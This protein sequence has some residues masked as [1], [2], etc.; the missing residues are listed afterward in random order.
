MEEQKECKTCH[1]VKPVTKFKYVRTN[2]K[3]KRYYGTECNSCRGIASKEITQK[4]EV[5]PFGDKQNNKC[6]CCFD[7]EQIK[8][9]LRLI[10]T[11]ELDIDKKD[12]IPK[13]FNINQDLYYK[14]QQYSKA[15][16]IND[17]D[18]INLILREFFK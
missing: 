8:L 18:S 1:E 10:D 4:E 17:S 3:G 5:T 7:A 13:T 12:R 11:K 16:Y 15:N 6:E 2:A 14:M 9:I